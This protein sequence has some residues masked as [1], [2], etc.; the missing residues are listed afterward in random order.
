MEI[1]IDFFKGVGFYEKIVK[2]NDKLKHKT[3]HL[4]DELNNVRNDL[5]G[6]INILEL[7][8]TGLK[9]KVEELENKN[10]DQWRN[11]FQYI[12]QY[13]IEIQDEEE[14]RQIL[15]NK[16]TELRKQFNIDIID[17]DEISYLKDRYILRNYKDGYIRSGKSPACWGHECKGWDTV[18]ETCEC[19][20]SKVMWN[21]VGN[22]IE[23]IFPSAVPNKNF[24]CV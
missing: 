16:L 6:K 12:S 23:H 9:K 24:E 11:Y 2:E 1:S 18:S 8:N 13:K 19:G 14:H 3:N 4:L 22:P 15:K 20:R 5:S 21:M 10:I 7:E 17:D